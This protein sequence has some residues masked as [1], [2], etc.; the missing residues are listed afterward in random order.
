MGDPGNPRTGWGGRGSGAREKEAE[1]RGG[2]E[3]R[4]RAGCWDGVV[5]CSGVVGRGKGRGEEARPESRCREK[6]GGAEGRPERDRES[7][8][9]RRGKLEVGREK[10]R[11]MEGNSG[12]DGVSGLKGPENDMHL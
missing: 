8:R 7:P 11:R 6:G 9:G 3:V 2:G 12:W 10:V 5:C 1:V 4:E